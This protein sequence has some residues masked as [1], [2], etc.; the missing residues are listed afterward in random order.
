M[1]IDTTFPPF[2][3]ENSTTGQ[4]VGREL[5]VKKPTLGCV[6]YFLTM[7]SSKVIC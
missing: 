2:V 6:G 1:G 3:H 4:G 5:L 7:A